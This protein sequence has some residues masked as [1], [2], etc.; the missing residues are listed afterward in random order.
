MGVRREVPQIAEEHGHLA[1]LAPEPQPA[2]VGQHPAADRG[3]EVPGHRLANPAL[4]GLLEDDPV[5]ESDGVSYEERAEREH[6][7]DDDATLEQHGRHDQVE[8]EDDEDEQ[9]HAKRA[10]GGREEAPQERHGDDQ[11]DDGRPGGGPEEALV[12]D[13][14]DRA[15]EDLDPPHAPIAGRRGGMLVD[16]RGRGPDE[17]D[18][19][20]HRVGVEGALEDVDERDDAERPAAPGLG[21]GAEE[22]D[23]HRIALGDG[24]RPARG[25]EEPARRRRVDDARAPR[26]AGHDDHGE[27][28]NLLLADAEQERQAAHHAVPG[29]GHVHDP[30]VE[31]GVP[32]RPGGADEPLELLRD[33]GARVEGPRPLGDHRR[34]HVGG[35][36]ER[37]RQLLV[38]GA[39]SVEEHGQADQPRGGHLERVEDSRVERPR[40]RRHRAIAG[41]EAARA[42]LVHAH[43][44]GR[45]RRPNRPGE[46]EEVHGARTSGRHRVEEE[47][48]GQQD[49]DR[50]REETGPEQ[51]APGGA[52]RGGAGRARVRRRRGA[53]G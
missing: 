30:L 16:P 18:L 23:E 52:S 39:R 51:A 20:P 21:R 12:Q 17:D 50:Q 10:S 40:P 6:Q 4:L 34:D 9:P 25:V 19:V 44:H 43:D 5:H 26:E 35:A 24:D 41:P 32:D 31:A 11:R 14:L 33:A 15:A 36:P 13:R 1:Q 28:R 46:E 27:A 38:L 48:R 3:R 53:P 47:G 2:G 45:G 37:R 7:V 22:V 8:A 42:P 49:G 29:R